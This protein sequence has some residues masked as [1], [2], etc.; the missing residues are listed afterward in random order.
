MRQ[1]YELPSEATWTGSASIYHEVCLFSLKY[2]ISCVTTDLRYGK[3]ELLHLS[4][5][6]GGHLTLMVISDLGTYGT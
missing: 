3:N 6:K 4:S 5:C 1:C 2:D